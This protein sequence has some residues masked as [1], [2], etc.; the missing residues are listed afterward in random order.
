MSSDRP[1]PGSGSAGGAAAPLSSI[2]G[3]L[4]ALAERL[5]AAITSGAS[6]IGTVWIV[7]LMLLINA[8]VIGR[9][10]FRAPLPGTPELVTLSIVGIVFL[11]LPDAARRRALTRS[12]TLI[13]FI[14]ARAPR[15]GEWIAAVYELVG[16][17]LFAILASVTFPLAVKAWAR[18]E[19]I[20]NPGLLTVPTWPLLGLILIGSVLLA[21]QFAVNAVKAVLRATGRAGNVR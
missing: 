15:L 12:E 3:W 9:W 17:V 20:G 21:A 8:D 10:L 5:L 2:P 4:A 1:E 11:Q 14:T 18:A 6:A 16:T 19:F 13:D 7:A